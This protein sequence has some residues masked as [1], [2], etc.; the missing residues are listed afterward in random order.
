MTSLRN[1]EEG[2]PFGLYID[3]DCVEEFDHF[4]DAYVEYLKACRK[5]PDS[6]IDLLSADGE[7]SYCG[8][9]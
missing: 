6:I 3:Y 5:Y 9:N 8:I 2:A 7:I 4:D 1:M